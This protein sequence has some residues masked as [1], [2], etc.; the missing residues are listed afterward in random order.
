[1]ETSSITHEVT[2]NAS[3]CE[4]NKALIDPAKHSAMARS[5]SYG[6]R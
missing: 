5:R 4:V 3:P 2:F 6:R 1:M